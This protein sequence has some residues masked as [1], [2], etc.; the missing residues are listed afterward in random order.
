M[1]GII[2]Q[3]LLDFLEQHGGNEL[4][5]RVLT[6]ANVDPSI[7]YRIDKNYSDDECLR[8]I[9]AAVI[10]TGLSETTVYQ[11]Y[12]T[13]FLKKAQALFPR[14]FEIADD[15]EGFLLRQARI[16]AVMA[17]GLKRQDERQH[18]ND[19]FSATSVEPGKV[20]VIY[21]SANGLCRLYQALA[22]EVA[23]LYDDKIEFEEPCCMHQG[24]VHCEFL[25]SWPHKRQEVACG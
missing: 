20:R 12:A 4:K 6:T 15:S 7:N 8:L 16:H 3:V 21:R 25:I 5:Q 24:A 14:F 19:K 9:N 2:Q 22:F 23:A 10:E 11:H 13:A 17:S 18:V 1:I